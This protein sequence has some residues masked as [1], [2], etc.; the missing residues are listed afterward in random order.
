MD[1]AALAEKWREVVDNPYLRDFPFKLELNEDGKVEF[2]MSPASNRHSHWRFRIGV[3]LERALGGEALVEC[4]I[5]TGKGVKVA[6]V[7]WCSPAF[8][9]RHGYE[10]PYP[11]APELCIEV[12]SPS[13]T[14]DELAKKTRLYLEA[15]AVEAWIVCGDGIME[16]YGPEGRRT[17]SL[18]GIAVAPL[19]L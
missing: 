8:L 9:A 16:V 13:N 12:A 6:D 2:A 15:G 14:S 4:S 10:T 18:F 17:Q 1:A 5:L 11:K 7:V 3:M 19:E